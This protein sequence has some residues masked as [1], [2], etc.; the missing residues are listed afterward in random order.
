M[1]LNSVLLGNLYLLLLCYCYKLNFLFI[2]I[3]LFVC[4]DKISEKCIQSFIM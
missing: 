4:V 1:R 2:Y 3:Y